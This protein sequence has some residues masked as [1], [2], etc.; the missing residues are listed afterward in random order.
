MH[1]IAFLFPGQGSQ[2][3]GMG[4]GLYEAEPAAREVFLEADD[5]LGIPLSDLIFGGPAEELTDT[6]NAQPA[7][8]TT[9]V[10]LLRSLQQE[11][12]LEPAFAAGHS[13]GEYTALVCA[14][15]LAFA[16]AL[17]LV[18]ERGRLMKAAGN[19]HPGGMAAVLGLERVA[20]T[21]ICA[22]AQMETG[23]AVQLANDNCPGQLVISGA[24]AALE[25]AMVLAGE[26]GA[27]RVV[28]LDVSIAAHS[29]LMAA[30]AVELEKFVQEA[31]IRPP[32]VPVIGNTTASPLPDR[33]AITAEL[34]AQ[35]TATVRWTESIEYLLVRGVDTFVEIGPKDVLTGLM[36]RIDRESRRFTVQDPAGISALGGAL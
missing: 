7:I 32:R 12:D 2:E 26:R 22:E 16:D 34:V 28:Q 19:E 15:A 11:L 10:A 33:A 5:I 31:D 25:R 8:L 23:R 27:R 24:Q 17:R 36:K 9:S 21:E 29:P 30:A 6:V 20:V 13:L 14:G 3:V 35:L 4:R 1:S 18:R